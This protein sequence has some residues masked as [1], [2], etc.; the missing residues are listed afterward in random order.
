M[1]KTEEKGW[2]IYEGMMKKKFGN[3]KILSKFLTKQ[4]L[5]IITT[6]WKER[7]I[8]F[9]RTFYFCFLFAFYN[10]HVYFLLWKVSN[11]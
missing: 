10:L 9:N 4:S 3:Q 6:K 2:K 8:V 1:K 11:T 7:L 5:R